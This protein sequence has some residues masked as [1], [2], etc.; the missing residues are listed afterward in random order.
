MIWFALYLVTGLVVASEMWYFAVHDSKAEHRP[1]FS[2][3]ATTAAL[4][5]VFWPLLLVVVLVSIIVRGGF[6]GSR[7]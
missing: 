5:G 6:G 1:T 3:K 2:E 7:P 4:A